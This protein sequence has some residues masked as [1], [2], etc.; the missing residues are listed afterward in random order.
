MPD[1]LRRLAAEFIGTFAICFAG[2]L[3]ITHGGKGAAG[4]LVSIALA[5]GLTVAVMI[6][7]FASVS[8]AHF[9]PAATLAFLSAGRI[10]AAHAGA[11]IL[12]QLAGAIAA[13][14]LLTLL[15]GPETAADGCTMLAAGVSA[16]QGCLLE[17]I[18]T[19]FLLLVAYGTAVN[20]DAPQGLFP[21]AIGLTVT[22]DILAIGPLT[23]AA[24]NPARALGPALLSG[25]WE[26]QWVFWLGPI[27]G[28]IAA[29]QLGRSL[30]PAGD[31][32]PAPQCQP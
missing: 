18:A 16:G 27:I 11:Y 15:F 24:L 6:A 9:N 23:G 32:A 22:L 1:L 26:M 30:F 14:A 12:A 20:R 5:F 4:D 2:M 3:A 25:R 29:A 10:P 17:A 8:G 21:W 13:S 7:C 31:N 28:A 19:C